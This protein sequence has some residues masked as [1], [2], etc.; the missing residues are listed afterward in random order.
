MEF[1]EICN[2]RQLE[3]TD[4]GYVSCLCY[5]YLHRGLS[6]FMKENMMNTI[7][8]NDIQRESDSLYYRYIQLRGAT[9]MV[10]LR[11]LMFIVSTLR[12]NTQR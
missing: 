5:D 12:M 11:I 8:Y 7:V 4:Q 6:V 9:L 3:L 2:N 1:Q 10:S